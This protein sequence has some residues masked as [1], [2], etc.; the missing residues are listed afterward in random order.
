MPVDVVSEIVIERPILAVASYAA[1]PDN[2]PEWYVNIESVEWKTPPPLSKGS[3]LAFVAH[4]LGRT[5][6]YTYEIVDLEPAKRLVMRTSEGPFPMET[7]YT[8]E[9]LAASGTTR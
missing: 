2:A 5:L 1:D 3:R 6:S 4:F 8:W 9:P 7:T